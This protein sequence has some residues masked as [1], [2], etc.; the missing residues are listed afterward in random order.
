M[1]TSPPNVFIS[2]SHDSDLHKEWVLTL[3]TRLVANGVNVLLDQWDLTLGSDLPRFMESGLTAAD[4]VLAICT[5]Q[6]VEKADA[7][8]GGVGYEKMILTAQ[9]MQNVTA[10]RI[11]PVIRANTLAQPVPIF[12]SSRVYIDFRDHLAYESRY[13]ELL[14]DIHGQGVKPRPPLG[15]NPFLSALTPT[16]PLI[17]FGPE[18]Y[19][20]PAPH[21]TVVFDYSNNNGR[22]VVGAGDMAF[23]TAW[24]GGSNSSVHAYTDPPSIR[25]VALAL[26][27]ANITDITDAA[28]YDTS[29]R[30]RSPQLGEIVVWQNTAGYFLATKI[31]KLQSRGHGCPVDEITFTYAIAPNK[32]ASFALA[33]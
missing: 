6:Y 1:T 3:A 7:G 22:Y 21:G 26:G 14:R 24:S 9:L 19:V 28:I 12:L 30:V 27:V 13:A 18:R 2:Y 5:N 25:S 29:S 31:E 20:S 16:A 11:I 8:M 10:D 4:R 33:K 15:A 23:E 17:S 32:L